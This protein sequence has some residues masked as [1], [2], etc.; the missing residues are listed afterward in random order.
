MKAD[1]VVRARVNEATKQEAAAILEA[2]GLSTSDAIRMMLIRVVEDKALP[3]DPHRPNATTI[4]AIKAARAGQVKKAKNSK[5]LL[6]K[7]NAKG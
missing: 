6:A 2:S 3:F 1:S 5:D 7:L 4:R